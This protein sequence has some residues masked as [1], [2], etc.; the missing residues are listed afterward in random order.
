MVPRAAAVYLGVVQFLF[1][2]TWTLYVIY[3]PSLAAKAGIAKE[4]VPWILVADQVVFALMDVVAGFWVDR[5]RAGLARLGGWILGAT[6]VSAAA[7]LALPF[8]GGSSTL[9][10]GA[11]LVWALTSSALRSPPWALLSRYA[12]APSVPWLSTLMLTGTAVAG[13][14]APY[15]GVAL[16]DVDPRLPFAISTLVLAA[17]VGG[18][19]WVE[20]RLQGA[21]PA[22]AGDADPPFDVA[23]PEGRRL[24]IA[25]FAG[26]ALLAA[27]FQVHFAMNSAGQYLRFAAREDL[28]WLMPVFWIGF[29]LAMFP[30]SGVVKRRGAVSVMAVA[31][32]LGALASAAAA[33][34]PGLGALVAAQ[35]VAGACWGA[36]S[37]AA[38]SAVVAF[39]RA[40]REGAMLGSLFA[41]LALAAFARIAATASGLP[42]VP[43]AKSLLPW[44]PNM[45]WLGAAIL[46][47]LVVGTA[48]RRAL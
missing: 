8:A 36:I 46:L 9:L 6:L 15:L 25:F 13:A 18:L 23:S 24:L 41:V 3:L 43:E 2:T 38:F 47:T 12:A 26:L 5:L 33:W 30:M 16:R 39:G 28:Q 1:A 35:L 31:G 34:A 45:A 42:A 21:Q 10:L 44:L 19:V 48:R 32:A 17:A 11:A 22:P 40:S 4:W 14:L 20:R 29:N 7:F 37:V 27:G